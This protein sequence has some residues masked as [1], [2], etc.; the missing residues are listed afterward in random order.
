M[1]VTALHPVPDRR[2]QFAWSHHVTVPEQPGCY[3]LVSYAGDVLYVGLATA[4]IRDRMGIHL[5]GPEK[6]KAGPAGVPFW[7]YYFL[8]SAVDVGAVERGWMNQAIM[9]DGTLPLL[10]R[11]YSPL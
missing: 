4:S 10:N 9:A 7:F 8:R 11:I 6:R 2:T 5:D 1:K 3:A